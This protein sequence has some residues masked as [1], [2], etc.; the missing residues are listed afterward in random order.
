MK[1][2]AVAFATLA[3]SAGVASAGGEVVYGNGVRQGGVAVPVPVPAPVPEVSTGYYVRIDAAY[4]QG[5][6]SKYKSTDPFVDQIRGDSYV[7]NF[8]RYGLGFGYYFNKNLR[9]DITIDQRNDATSR[10]TGNRD[11]TVAN[12]AGGLNATG[13]ALGPI[14]MRD[15]YSDSFTSSNSTGLA[16]LY[17][18]LPVSERF[19]PYIGAGIGYVRHQL[20]GRSFSRVTQCVDTSDCHPTLVDAQPGAV[21]LN[22]TTTTTAGGINYQLAAALMAGFTYKVWDN[23]KLDIGYRWLH[24][25]GTS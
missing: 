13:G 15:T 17:A 10:G 1:T 19:T 3:A 22:T 11:Y 16:N 20:K 9:G 25:Q 6:V 21:V 12:P 14:A 5:D 23:T 24:L 8:P 2:A 4:S 18:D 7:D